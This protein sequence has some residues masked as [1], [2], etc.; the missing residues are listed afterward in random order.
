MKNYQKW[1]KK[2]KDTY[3][4]N[5]TQ[6]KFYIEKNIKKEKYKEQPI[7]VSLESKK[8]ILFQME[9]C[10]CKIYLKN[11]ETGIGFLCKFPFNNNVLITNNNILNNIDKNKCIILNFNSE[12][13][14]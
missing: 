4:K 2:D 6:Y 9:N 14:K 5:K 12:V 8:Q 11:D 1:T 13:K 7:S 10:V 3:L